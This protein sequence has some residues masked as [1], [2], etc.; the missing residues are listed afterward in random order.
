MPATPPNST[1]ITNARLDGVEE[2]IDVL[3]TG[4]I[5]S[6]I[7]AAAADGA[8]PNTAT[9][10]LGGRLLLPAAVEPHAHL[11]KAFLA[12]RIPNPT[13]DLM[14]AILAM[15]E[16]R[17]LTTVDIAERAERAGRLM[18]TNG[19]VAVRTHVDVT[20]E[21]GLKS[22]EALAHV[23]EQL[24]E[25]ITIE[26][27]ALCGWPVVGPAGANQRALLH[28]AMAAGADL[29]GGC[30][31]LDD[32]GTRASTEVFLGI[33]ADLG[34]G[35]DLH[36]DET[37]DPTV[38][39]LSDLCEA[40]L[41]G[42]AQSATAS[43]CVSLGQRSESDQ[44]EIA[45]LVAAAGVN[46]VTLPHTNL[47]L[48]GRGRTPMPRALTAVDALRR[49]GANVAA[50]ADNLQDPFNPVGRACPFETAGLMIMA[51]HLL[52]H[53]AWAMVSAAP[54]RALGLG[55]G[56][57]AVGA[58]ADLLAVDATTLREAIAFGPAGRMRW[59]RGVL[60]GE[61]ES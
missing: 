45:A 21:N 33:A 40:V 32:G 50:G 2:L 47:F 51:A 24:S 9:V 27:V 3:C 38:D 31:H 19:F 54:A 34:V 12:E 35:V 16:H 14:G 1:L 55:A 49:A 59:R 11:D 17:A 23:R 52:P 60:T 57:V 46:V 28:D 8:P 6:A 30:P 25:L 58:S 56:A 53:E 29:V 4:G 5:I 36:T 44:H 7:G 13:G 15:A 41:D 39:G 37:L 20:L 10:D 61:I 42:F 18:A 43:H 26:I 48:Q 22:V